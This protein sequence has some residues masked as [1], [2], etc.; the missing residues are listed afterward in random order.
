MEN[1]KQRDKKLEEIKNKVINCKKC[2]LYK[3]RIYPVIGQGSHEAKFVF[4]GEAPGKNEDQ[5]GKPFCGRSGKIL[6]ELLESIDLERKDIYICNILKCRPPNNRDPQI[7]EIEKCSPYLEEQIKI[8][9]PQVL[10]SLGRFSMEFLINKF[11][12]E[13]NNKS[14]SENHGKI[15][16]IKISS[17]KMVLIP[18]Y[19]PAVAIYNPNMKDILKKDFQVLKNY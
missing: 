16:E 8:I 10:C 12:L 14:I 4:I 11:G 3:K 17:K 9:N 5:T 18:L 7:D 13:N 1:I 6:D 2:N 19:H 15:L